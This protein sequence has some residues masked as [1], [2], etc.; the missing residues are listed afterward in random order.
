[1]NGHLSGWLAAWL[2]NFIFAALGI[3]LTLRT[4]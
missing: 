3:V 1:M 4:R 2:P